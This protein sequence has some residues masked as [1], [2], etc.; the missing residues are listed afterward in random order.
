MAEGALRSRRQVERRTRR[1]D[2]Q[3]LARMR[4]QEVGVAG[5]EGRFDD[6]AVVR[7]AA[8]PD[9]A[10]DR[11]RD[12]N[13]GDVVEKSLP[14]LPPQIRVEVRPLDPR[15]QPPQAKRRGPSDASGLPATRPPLCRSD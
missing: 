8:G 3:I 6:L 5:D 11:Y 13:R 9:R 7:V 14:T 2:R 12:C 1:K 15:A 4:R 10:G